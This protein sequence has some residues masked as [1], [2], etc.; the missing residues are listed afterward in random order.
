MFSFSRC[1]SHNKDR[2]GGTSPP[3]GW[4]G[5]G[6]LNLLSDPS[7]LRQNFGSSGYLHIAS[8]ALALLPPAFHCFIRV[9]C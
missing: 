3:L 8:S 2:S 4:G 9:E 1:G 5:V 7:D 6:G